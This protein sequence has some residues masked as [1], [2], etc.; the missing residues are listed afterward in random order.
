VSARQRQAWHDVPV[1]NPVYVRDLATGKSWLFGFGGALRFV[2]EDGTQHTIGRDSRRR[3]RK[4][5]RR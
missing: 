2:G 5:A 1:R 4:R 3:W